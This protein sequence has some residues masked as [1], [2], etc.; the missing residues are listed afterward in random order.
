VNN[1]GS[2]IPEE[3]FRAK[4][5]HNTMFTL[6]VACWRIENVEPC[7][8]NMRFIGIKRKTGIWNTF[9]NI[10]FKLYFTSWNTRRCSGFKIKWKNSS[11][12]FVIGF[13]IFATPNLVGIGYGVKE[14]N[15]YVAYVSRRVL[16]SRYTKFCWNRLRG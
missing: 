13:W 6:I 15:S 10:C 14:L 5:C 16:N 1:L 3:G 9:Q 12:M 8:P 11:D 2:S 7:Y 4:T